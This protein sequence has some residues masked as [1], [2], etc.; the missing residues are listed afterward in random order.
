MLSKKQLLRKSFLS[1][2]SRLKTSK[3]TLNDLLAADALLSCS[4]TF[5]MQ[6]NKENDNE[7]LAFSDGELS[8]RSNKSNDSESNRPIHRIYSF[9]NM[10]SGSEKTIKET[11]KKSVT[12]AENVRVKRIPSRI[13]YTCFAAD[14]WW[15]ADECKGF[16]DESFNEIKQYLELNHNNY[17]SVK[18]AVFMMYQVND[19]TIALLNQVTRIS[20]N[21][22]DC[23]DD[24]NSPMKS[25]NIK[26]LIMLNVI[27]PHREFVR[28]ESPIPMDLEI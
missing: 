13:E 23:Y 17:F 22:F 7:T 16:R 27:S 5:L 9:E 2:I 10:S 1:R 8:S 3:H 18:E 21:L 26:E 14:L 28:I 19:E 4:A 24:T 25:S 11:N 15:T 12:F 20:N 6:N